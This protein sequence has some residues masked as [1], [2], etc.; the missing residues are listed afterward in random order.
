MNSFAASP[1]SRP[2]LLGVLALWMAFLSP[3]VRSQTNGLGNEFQ[4]ETNA[5]PPMFF[6]NFLTGTNAPFKYVP[7]TNFYIGTNYP[8]TYV[9]ITNFQLGTNVSVIYELTNYPSWYYTNF[10]TNWGIGTNIIGPGTNWSN[11]APPAPPKKPW[12]R[13]FWDW[14]WRW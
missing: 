7:T 4:T 2:A 13:R 1:I 11:P 6:T 3:E 9:P 5:L 12:W 8:F 10:F 14:L